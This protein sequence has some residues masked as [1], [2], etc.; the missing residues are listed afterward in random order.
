MTR[1]DLWTVLVVDD[2]P[3]V[4]EITRIVL[5]HL[6]FDGRGLDI[7]EA[8]SAREGR[9]VLAQRKDVALMIIDVVMETEHAG[10]DLV[11]HVREQMKNRLSRIVLR[12]GHPGQAPEREVIRAF[13]IND[14]K[15]KT[16]LT[17]HK[18]E[19]TV[20]VALRGYRDLMTIEAAREGLER[21]VE[22][23]A[24][25]HS[26]H[27]SHEFASAVLAQLAALVGLQRGALY[28][29]VPK[30]DHTATGPIHVTAAT[31]EFEPNV[32]HRIDES[33]PPVVLR[34]FYEAYD[35]KRHVFGDDHYVLYFTDAQDSEN[36]LIVAGASRLSELDLH[37]VRVFC[38]NVGI[39][40]EN[41]HL[42]QDLLDSQLE[43]VCLLAGAA[44]TRSQETAN[45][46]KRVGLLAEFLAREY[47][48]DEHTAEAI[49]FAAPLHDIGKIAVPD[50][51]LNKP[52][53][54]TPEETV[55]MRMHVE[56]GAQMLT[57][58]RLPLIR[59]ASEIAWTH[60]ENWDG[61]GYPRG[62]SKT[63]IPIAGRITALADVYDALG[64]RRCY[65]EP[66]AQD[67]VLEFI[68]N[69]RGRK[70]EPRLVD[71]LIG[72]LEKAEAVRRMLPD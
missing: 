9:E 61:S 14:Y 51:V 38:T 6:D 16:E 36:L 24:Q 66:W 26:R 69:E 22:A 19:T 3:D 46:V 48:L 44:E 62:L 67:K 49:R 2:E 63:Q 59:L 42:N 31:G 41:L 57:Q 70:F 29:S 30:T 20:L 10:L 65:K 47:G 43:M 7:I 35:H 27:Q 12:T 11:R 56:H 37:L 21:V 15:E 54:H 68:R 71:I 53:Q 32:A 58:S 5:Q 8:G 28:C 1:D 4:R 18:L 55:I 23:S 25:I 45:H 39:A 64:S 52:G 34:S 13:D 17:A 33:L 50:Y 72:K 40:F 60:H